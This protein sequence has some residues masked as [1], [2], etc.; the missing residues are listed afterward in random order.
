MMGSL[1][2]AMELEGPLSWP[3]SFFVGEDGRF[4]PVEEPP[5]ARFDDPV[6]PPVFPG[7]FSFLVLDAGDPVQYQINK[8]FTSNP[9][10]TRTS[11]G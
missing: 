5:C 1:G 2:W 7:P 8:A 6:V 4:F 10:A 3:S 9:M 11:G